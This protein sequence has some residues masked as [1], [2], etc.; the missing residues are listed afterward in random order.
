MQEISTLPASA[1]ALQRG[2]DTHKGHFGSVAVIGGAEGMCGAA[3]LAGR[4]ALLLGAGKVWVGLLDARLSV[5]ILQPELMLSPAETLL[6]QHQPSHILAG[7]GMGIS[8][9]AW[10]LLRRCMDTPAPLLL[11][12]DALNL[13]A[14]DTALQAH[15]ARRSA[16]T[17]LTPHPSEAARLLGTSTAAVQADRLA[18]MRA[19]IGRY[20]C[21]IVLKGHGTLV[22]CADELTINRSG[23]AALSSA[24]QGDVL[25]GIIMSLCAQG[26]A[27]MD[28]ARCGVYL[29]GRA[30]D[31]WLATHPA[32]IGLTASETII[33]ARQA[34]NKALS[35]IS[36]T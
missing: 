29:H 27:L 10:Q 26:L 32:G 33:L 25:S 14:A 1:K 9:E 15:L 21:H 5:D 23:N 36:N 19:L 30:A 3:L 16:P 20:Q 34:L 24:G 17:V 35:T 12:A 8:P 28:A 4:A 31:D 6:S 2:N 7:M 22:G 11:D 18:A 13:I